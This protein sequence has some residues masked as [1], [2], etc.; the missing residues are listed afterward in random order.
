MSSPNSRQPAHIPGQLATRKHQNYPKSVE[1]DF[2]NHAFETIVTLQPKESSSLFDAEGLERGSERKRHRNFN[3]R[4]L[5][6]FALQDPL[7]A[8]NF[9]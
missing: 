4:L 6:L 3:S 1:T 7:T 5:F 9:R 8:E 2:I